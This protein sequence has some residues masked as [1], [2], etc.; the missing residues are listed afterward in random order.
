MAASLEKRITNFLAKAIKTHGDLYDYSKVIYINNKT[1]VKIICPEHGSFWQQPMVHL[2]GS[3]CQ[4]CGGHSE[5]TKDIFIV[6]ANEKHNSFYNYDNIILGRM[7]RH[8]NIICP[9]HGSFS[10]RPNNHIN[11][12]GCPK[13]YDI[14]KRY[15]T[16]QFIENAIKIHG[17][18]Y[19]YNNVIYINALTPVEIICKEH[20]SFWQRPNEHTIGKSGCSDCGGTKLITND[21]FLKRA[22]NIH[23]HKY[24]YLE[25]YVT[26]H[27]RLS[28]KCPIHGIF[29]QQAYRHLQGSI[30]PECSKGSGGFNYTKS[31]ILY[32][33]QDVETGYYKLGITNNS[34]EIRFGSL[35]KKIRP[36]KTW[37]FNVGKNAYRVEQELHKHFI[38]F[39]IFNKNFI[40][41]GGT[42][43]FNKDILNLDTKENNDQPRL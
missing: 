20:G 12:T 38:E 32:Y 37:F 11:G 23:N 34:V 41:N 42:E 17:G 36:I 24:I 19:N 27:Y 14:R 29:K 33:I 40:N 15:S 26:S 30:C 7:D 1:R 4:K 28:I 13:C 31:G 25:K 10:Q 5:V 6:K 9:E 43:F 35:F 21:I 16:D 22:N 3:G 2:M 39:S 18:T 8:I